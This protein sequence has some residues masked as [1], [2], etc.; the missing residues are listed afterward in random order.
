MRITS[1]GQ[2][3]IPQQVRRALGL[4]PGDEV[5][6]IIDD[7][8]ARIIPVQ[9]PVGRGKRIVESMLGKG[10]VSLSTDEIMALTRGE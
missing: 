10:D 8:V 3:T 6:I 4:E 9:G 5:D 1:K 2:I 7:G